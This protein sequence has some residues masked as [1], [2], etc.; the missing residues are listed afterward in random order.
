MK[1][2]MWVLLCTLC[3]CAFSETQRVRSEDV[4]ETRFGKKPDPVPHLPPSPPGLVLPPQELPPRAERVTVMAGGLVRVRV[5]GSQ[6][7]VT[8]EQPPGHALTL[9]RAQAPQG[10]WTPLFHSDCSPVPD[11]LT[12]SVT[13]PWAERET[14]VRGLQEPCPRLSDGSVLVPTSAA[15]ALGACVDV[16]EG[17]QRVR[18]VEVLG[19]DV[20]GE[21]RAYLLLP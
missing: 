7:H 9:L 1:P 16:R 19:A 2:V 18:L 11:T 4:P 8:A 6:L 5:L 13:G 15:R 17:P 3:G 14:F 20:N 12:W 10:P 21:F